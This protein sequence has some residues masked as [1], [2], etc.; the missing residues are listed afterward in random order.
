VLRYLQFPPVN[1]IASL[2][3]ATLSY[4]VVE[5]P[6]L[7]IGHRFAPPATPGRRDLKI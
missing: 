1:L 3:C 6:L 7:R 5:K 2:A 4:Y